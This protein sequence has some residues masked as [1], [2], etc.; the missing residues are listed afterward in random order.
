MNVE[1][2]LFSIKSKRREHYNK[3]NWIAVINGIFN[4]GKIEIAWLALQGN[5]HAVLFF[6]FGPWENVYAWSLIL[7]TQ[8][9]SPSHYNKNPIEPSAKVIPH[10][11]PFTRL[12]DNMWDPQATH[13]PRDLMLACWLKAMHGPNNGRLMVLRR[14]KIKGL[15]SGF[16]PSIIIVFIF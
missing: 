5:S 13:L 8:T 15:I 10:A 11:P 4:F 9:K 1:N 12:S 3:W 16:G 2:F 14:G 6:C 7:Q